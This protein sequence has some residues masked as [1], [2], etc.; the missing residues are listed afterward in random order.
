MNGTAGGKA[1]DDDTQVGYGKPPKNTRFKP[2]QSGNPAGR[3]KG[4]QTLVR[5]LREELEEAVTVRDGET[6]R[7]LSR[8]R[9]ILR[10]LTAKAIKGDTRATAMVFDLVQ[11]LIGAGPGAEFEIGDGPSPREILAERI[12]KIRRSLDAEERRRDDEEKC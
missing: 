3:P 5:D 2:G 9:S 10:S 11:R 1:M 8:Q 6:E 12:E 7:T 4:P